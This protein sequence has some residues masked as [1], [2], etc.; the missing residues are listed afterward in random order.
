MIVDVRLH[1][2]DQTLL[3]TFALFRIVD[4]FLVTLEQLDTQK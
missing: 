4:A 2:Q 1:F 3:K